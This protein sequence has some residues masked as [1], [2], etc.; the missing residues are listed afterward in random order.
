MVLV[1]GC[2]QHGL[3]QPQRDVDV[4][5]ARLLHGGGPRPGRHA[6]QPARHLGLVAGQPPPGLGQVEAGHEA[7]PGALHVSR[8]TCHRPGLAT[9]TCTA[10]AW[11]H[12]SP[13]QVR[14]LPP[15]PLLFP[16]PT[17]PN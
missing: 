3:R 13:A 4:D 9:P 16:R 5:E 7:D 1:A 15:P 14:L 12:L 10:S 6:D 2:L 8:V 17:T 11:L